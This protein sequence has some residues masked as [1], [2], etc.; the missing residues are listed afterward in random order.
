MTPP[1]LSEPSRIAIEDAFTDAL[2]ALVESPVLDEP[3]TWHVAFLGQK[4]LRLAG[5]RGRQAVEEL[6]AEGSTLVDVRKDSSLPAFPSLTAMLVMPFRRFRAQGRIIKSVKSWRDEALAKG[7]LVAFE[8]GTGKVA[9][10][11]SHTYARALPPPRSASQ[12]LAC[13][14]PSYCDIPRR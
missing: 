10:F 7:W 4:L 3:H 13:N 6:L 12:M 9:I 5:T 8:E 1:P 11:I 14:P 2:N